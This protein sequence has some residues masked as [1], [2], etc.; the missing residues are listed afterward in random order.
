VFQPTGNAGR[1]ILIGPG[2][3]NL[4]FSVFKNNFIKPI[5]EDFDVQFRPEFFNFL[6]HANFA[7][8]VTPDNVTIFDSTGVRVPGA[9]LLTSTT[10]REIQSALELVW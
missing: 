3:P 2:T 9:G 4:D 7:V 6:N 8:P 5:S 10:A 1:N